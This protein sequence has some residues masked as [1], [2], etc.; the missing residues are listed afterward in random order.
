MPT[1]PTID[2]LEAYVDQY[3]IANGNEEITGP[4]NNDALNGCIEFIRKSPLNWNKAT[5]I[6]SGGIVAITDQYTAVVVFMT[7]TPTSL[8][9][10]D[11]IYHEYVFINLTASAIPLAGLLVYYTPLATSSNEI[12]ANS[13]VN[14]FKA[15]NDLWVQGNNLPGGG[16]GSAQKQPFSFR[17]GVTANAP[18]AGTDT[19][20]LPAFLNSWVLLTVNRTPIDLSDMGDGSPYVTKTLA[21]DTLTINNYGAGWNDGDVLTYTLITP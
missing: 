6:S 14:V 17:V 9:W 19:W 3:I 11:N 15:S 16:T 12:P 20:T 2:A 5:L 10:T 13:V 7:V 21:S 18:T 4:I 1:F 8:T